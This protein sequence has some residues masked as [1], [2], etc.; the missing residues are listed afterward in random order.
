MSIE[1]T[2]QMVAVTAKVSLLGKGFDWLKRKALFVIGL[3][4]CLQLAV[5]AFMVLDAR[6]IL[7]SGET[8][9]LRVIPIDPRD[10]F[11]GEYVILNYAINRPLGD[12]R[13]YNDSW[14]APGTTIYVK[15][16]PENDGT[17]W[18]PSGYSFARPA[19][20]KFIRGRTK[21][22]NYVEFGI[23]SYFLQEGEGSKYE[24][25]I[26]KGT[27]SAEIALASDGRAILRR[28]LFEPDA[29]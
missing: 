7:L 6:S 16:V 17:H 20:G 8:V 18:Q 2:N 28:L 4:V 25:A 19:S 12:D 10:F 15:L 27:V 5:I 29:K 26:L 11:R 21:F 1:S 9:R 22:Y 23:E 13:L 14:P 24:E 3:G